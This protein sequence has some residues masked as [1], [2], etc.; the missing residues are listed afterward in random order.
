MSAS[1]PATRALDVLSIPYRV[2]EHTHPPESLEEAANERGQSPDQIIRS[3][4]FRYQKGNFFLTLAAGP[5]QV[6][7]RKLRAHLGVSRVSMANEDEVL[8]VTGYAVGTVSPLGLARPI[9]IL[10]DSGIFI[11]DEVS[12]GSGVRGVAIIMKSEDLRLSLGK[13]ELGQFC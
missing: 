8:A 10:A 4:L 11:Q 1:T 12:L 9:P 7:W 3:I 13:I 2:F 5:R 6:S